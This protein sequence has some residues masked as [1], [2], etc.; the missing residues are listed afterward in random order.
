MIPYLNISAVTSEGFV[1]K[2]MNTVTGRKPYP[3]DVDKIIEKAKIDLYPK[4]D[5]VIKLFSR[6]GIK[7]VQLKSE[8]LKLMY[9]RAYNPDEPVP[10]STLK[11]IKQ[12]L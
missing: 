11:L 12:E 5:T 10:F 6:I 8:Q 1:Q 9:R 2:V 4:R 3:N 7:A